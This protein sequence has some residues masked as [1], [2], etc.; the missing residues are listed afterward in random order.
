MPIDKRQIYKNPGITKKNKTNDACIEYLKNKWRTI[1]S[2][3]F[4]Y[5]F[6]KSPE[7]GQ[8]MELLMDCMIKGLESIFL[9]FSELKDTQFN[10]QVML[11]DV[12]A[13]SQRMAE[14]LFYYRL[15][16]MGFGE[17]KSKDAGP[18]FVAEKNGEIFCFEVVTPTPHN[19]IR[20]LIG[21][22]KLT[23]QDRDLLFRERLLSVTSAVK[24]KLQKF[25][26]H[27]LAGHVPDGAHYIIVVNDSLLLPYNQPWYGVMGE[28]CFGNSTLP[29]VVDATLG[30]GDIDFSEIFGD[31]NSEDDRDEFQTLIMKGN[32]Q[33]SIDEGASIT[34][35][36]SV[37]RVKKSKQIPTR[38][39]DNTIDVDII[40]SVGATGI[41]QITLREDLMFM[42]SFASSRTII[43]ASALISSVKNKELV[44]K[45]IFFTSTYAKDEDLVQPH[46]SP[47]LIFGYEPRE[48]NNQAIYD[49]LFKPFLKG[50]EFYKIP[51]CQD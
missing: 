51:E 29:I 32:F 45:S 42:H 11:P 19:S 13:Y 1:L 14:M 31:D 7:S 26:E 47:A 40:E 41:Y 10:K 36:D 8:R 34:S 33:I 28:L 24:D 23:P 22:S 21:Q 18:D 12:G 16:G 37:L 15:L 5:F 2:T 3:R 9:S 50:G 48:F 6:S 49:V 39:G 20:E 35:G 30:S 44:R 43:P 27:K 46:M 4:A 17:I 38:N 25:E